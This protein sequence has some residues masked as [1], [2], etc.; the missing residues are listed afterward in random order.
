MDLARRARG[1]TVHYE[2]EAFNIDDWQALFIGHGLLPESWDPAVDRTAPEL[3]Q[4]ELGRIHDFIRRKV[5]EQ[6][7]HAAYLQSVCTRQLQ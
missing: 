5:E 4:Q 7:T 3:R 6:R 1:E 2:D